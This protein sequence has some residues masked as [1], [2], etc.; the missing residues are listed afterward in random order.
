MKPL[1][2]S[3]PLD[4]YDAC[5]IIP[6]ES[7][8]LKGLKKHPVTQGYLCPNMNHFSEYERIRI[9]RLFGQPVSME[10]ALEKMYEMFAKTESKKIL[11]YRGSGNIGL[12]QRSCEHFFARFNATGTSGSLC[13]GAGEAGVL[14][15][16]G[17]NYI[18]S[19]D[20]IARSEVI[21][22]WGRN[23]HATHSHLLPV[24][25]G[26]TVIVIDPVR[27]KMA[28]MADLYIQIR[29]KCD[30][31]LALILS[32]FVMIEGSYDAEYLQEHAPDY[33]S[34]YELTQTLRI[35]ST[36]EKIDVS[37]GQI[38]DFLAF[39]QGKRTAI[40][41]GAGV[42]KYRIGAD[43]VRAIDGLGMLLG[44]FA[45]EGSG[46]SFLG[47]SSKGIDFPFDSITRKVSK[48]TVDFAQFET[49]FVQGANPLAQMPASGKVRSGYA[50]VPFSIYFGLYENETS[51]ASALVIPAKS[52]LEKND[53]RSSYG[54]YTFEEMPKV[55][56][57]SCG[58]SEFE[59][60]AYL[61]DRFSI[62]LEEELTY[63]NHFRSQICYDGDVGYRKDRPEVPYEK[64][65]KKGHFE[66]IDEIDAD[67]AEEEGFFLVTPKQPK[68]LNS[69]FERQRGVWFHPETGFEEGSKVRLTSAQGSVVMEV[70][71]DERLRQDTL[72]I[73]SGTP[74][75]NCLTP[76]LLS[77]DGE[78]AVYQEYKIKVEKV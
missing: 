9:P 41:I 6:E 60:T 51:L 3:C 1:I 45:Q 65:F 42:Q 16:R 23:L 52:F 32:R 77:Y 35:K 33:E 74:D 49:V 14:A 70:R 44:L 62:T 37:L 61:C 34:F 11:Y 13:D 12:M 15:G 24:L 64:G 72:L 26:K 31:Y 68:G 2:T 7:G 59:L 78:N 58:I 20:M 53:F 57:P 29:P 22:V 4:C 48:A 30:M 19:P 73:Y 69:Q 54:D 71:H 50:E 75:V 28:E 76:A 40:L 38:G 66:F 21:V 43:V 56:E 67:F 18:L 17:E 36:L 8:K 39:V 25:K 46:V 63:L 5:R 47:H 10:T 27:T 55:T